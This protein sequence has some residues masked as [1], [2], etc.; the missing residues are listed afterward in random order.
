M[1]KRGRTI[2][3]LAT[4]F[5]VT[6]LT[7]CASGDAQLRPAIEQARA[8]AKEVHL[9]SGAPALAVAVVVDGR[10]V[11]KDAFGVADAAAGRS[12]TPETAFRIGSVS[13][14]LT[15][16]ALLR[17]V[18]RG[19]VRLDERVAKYV[20]AFP[21]N[22]VTVGQLAY[23]LG[24]VRHYGR[25]E[26]MNTTHYATVGAALEKFINDPLV[27]PPGEKYVY[28]SYGYN[29]LGAVLERAAGIPFEEVIAREVLVPFKMQSTGVSPPAE[30]PRVR[31]YGKDQAGVIIDAPLI[32]LSD[33]VP[34]GGYLSTASNLARFAAGIMRLPK[35]S[36][37]L[38]FRSAETSSG[39]P[40]GVALGWR[41]A[42][43]GAGRSYV[44][45]GGD[46]IGGRAFVLIYP[47][48]RV[49]V[50]LLSNLSFAPFGEKE[51]LRI[52]AFFVGQG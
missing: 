22:N 51:A 50:V 18:E 9:V 30:V 47:D 1:L 52:A 7:A 6:S 19:V 38:L 43:D 48:Q 33:R 13:K 25:A 5:I 20:P 46:S 23:H 36:R 3:I 14:V 28:S 44:H 24:G 45:H 32:D 29:L 34:S 17:F 11:L 12:A 10:I 15:S 16:L 8:A 41:V 4:T 21:Q 26:Y 31:F 2:C 35:K 27:A 49:G 39:A 37:N 40:T 42:A